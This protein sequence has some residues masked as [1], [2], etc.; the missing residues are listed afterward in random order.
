MSLTLVSSFNSVTRGWKKFQYGQL[1]AA[2]L[3]YANL[4]WVQNVHLCIYSKT[5]L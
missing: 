4:L 5:S 1:A 2:T 3:H